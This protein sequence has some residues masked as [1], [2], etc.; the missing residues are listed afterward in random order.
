MVGKKVNYLHIFQQR[1]K[2][3]QE[4]G[5]CDYH[6][7]NQKQTDTTDTDRIFRS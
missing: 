2:V 7:R 1:Q 4:V 3:K 6:H 5:Y